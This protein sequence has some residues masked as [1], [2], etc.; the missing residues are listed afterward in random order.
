MAV[1]NLMKIATLALRR[2]HER[3]WPAADHFRAARHAAEMWD[4]ADRALDAIGPPNLKRRKP[5]SELP[6]IDMFVSRVEALQT[7]IQRLRNTLVIFSDPLSWRR[8]GICDPNSANFRG[9][10]IANDVLSRS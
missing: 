1:D 2:I 4:I 5:M 8:D 7:E 3:E 10:Q 6:S 9:R